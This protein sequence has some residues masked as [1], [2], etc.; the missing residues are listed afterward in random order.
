MATAQALQ[1]CSNAMV[2]ISADEVTSFTDGTNEARV[3]SALYERTL[4][5]AL[6]EHR[7]N[8][9]IDQFQA[10]QR[11][12]PA[13]S[14]FLK[15]YDLPSPILTLDR[16]TPD[17]IDYELFSERRILTDY[18]GELWVEGVW[19]VDE[20]AM[21]DYFLE[22]MEYRLASKFAFPI[23]ADLSLAKEMESKADIFQK[24]AK[25]ADSKQRKGV[26]IKKFPLIQVRG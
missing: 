11:L 18:D 1:I 6:T 7:W 10:S 12:A 2:L 15:Q 3:A 26:G 13:K 5:S 9:C 17:H 8:F 21:P 25:A 14:R 16:L 23:T 24:K 20:T 4:R 22:Y 19:R